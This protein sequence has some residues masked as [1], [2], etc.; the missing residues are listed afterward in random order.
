MTIASYEVCQKKPQNQKP[1][2]HTLVSLQE[3]TPFAKLSINLVGPLRE[4]RRGNTYL[5]TVKDCFSPW[6]EAFPTKT[7]TA[8]EVVSLLEKNIF[9]KYGHPRQIHSD[10]GSQFTANFFRAVCQ[11]LG[12]EVTQTPATIQSPT[13]WRGHT[14]ISTPCFVHFVLRVQNKTG[15]ASCQPACLQCVQLAT[16]ILVTPHT[17]SFLKGK[18]QL[19]LTS[20]SQILKRSLDPIPMSTNSEPDSTTPTGS[21]ETTYVYPHSVQ[22]KDTKEKYKENHS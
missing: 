19:P 6:L 18:L 2:R 15:K 3:G 5:L 17:I 14:E 4:S 11:K 7:I 13:Q 22:G 10:Q 8:E 1:Q 21:P 12:I 20:S 9:S 16:V